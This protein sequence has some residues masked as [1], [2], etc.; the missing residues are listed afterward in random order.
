MSSISFLVML[1]QYSIFWQE[2]PA[3]IQSGEIFNLYWAGPMWEKFRVAG[4]VLYDCVEVWGIIIAPH[5]HRPCQI[6]QLICLTGLLLL[7]ASHKNTEKEWLQYRTI[8]FSY[9]LTRSLQDKTL[10]QGKDIYLQTPTLSSVFTWLFNVATT[11]TSSSTSIILLCQTVILTTRCNDWKI[12]SMVFL[13]T[14]KHHFMDLPISA[15]AFYI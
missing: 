13:I 8:V 11:T 2:F 14:L 7:T 1:L 3:I 10:I 6:C 4:G 5:E 12:S 9:S 15:P